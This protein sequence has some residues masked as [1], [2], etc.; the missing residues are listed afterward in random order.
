M[1]CMGIKGLHTVRAP[2]RRVP[3]G[4]GAALPM[5]LPGTMHPITPI[6]RMVSGVGRDIHV[7]GVEHSEDAQENEWMNL[8]EDEDILFLIKP[9]S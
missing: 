3:L 8:C 7:F 5:C 6:N 2:H 1:L 9:R 4:G